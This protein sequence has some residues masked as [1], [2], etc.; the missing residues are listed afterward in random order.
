M[1]LA[2]FGLINPLVPRA[3]HLASAARFGLTRGGPLVLAEPPP[4][5]PEEAEKEWDG[6]SAWEG[7]PA[8]LTSLRSQSKRSAGRKQSALFDFSR[9]LAPVERL[10]GWALIDS[11]SG[12]P[13]S[14]GWVFL[15]LCV[16]AQG[17]LAYY[18][19]WVPLL[20]L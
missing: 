9:Q 8:W 7:E 1:L 20:G 19:V 5:P 4:P 10:T 6:F 11:V 13:R 16:V 15:G 3:S 2:V 18:L 14:D 17:C 12:R